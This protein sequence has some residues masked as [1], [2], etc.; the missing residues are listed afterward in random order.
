MTRMIGVHAEKMR[1][2]CA[3][4]CL[5]GINPRWGKLRALSGLLTGQPL[6][7]PFYRHAG[8]Q[9][10]VDARLAAGVGNVLTYSSAMARFVMTTRQPDA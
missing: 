9:Q 2:L 7:L 6:T 10:W 1:A 5:V 8:M 4:T 3:S